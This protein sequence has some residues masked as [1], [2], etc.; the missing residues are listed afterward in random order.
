MP[1]IYS[2]KQAGLFGAAAAGKARKAKGL[3]KSAAKR[4]LRGTN[5]K[6]LP[7]RSRRSKR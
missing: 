5:V 2:K 4:G 1:K 7:K 6:R 3:S